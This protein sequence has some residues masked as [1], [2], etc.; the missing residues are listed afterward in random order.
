[1]D[2]KEKEQVEVEETEI[3]KAFGNNEPENKEPQ[4][5]ETPNDTETEDASKEQSVDNT[6]TSEKEEQPEPKEQEKTSN[7]S[8]QQ[9]TEDK[10]EEQP[11]PTNDLATGISMDKYVQAELKGVM[12]VCDI[13]P[14]KLGRAVRLIDPALC[15]ENGEFSEQKANQEV[16]NLLAEWPELKRTQQDASGNAFYFGVPGQKENEQDKV[17]NKISSIFGNK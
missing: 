2:E 5:Q 13:D 8:D 7:E 12:A 6:E 14:K 3:Q 9:E 15:M 16:Q 4:E 11:N 10:A 17:N 1:M